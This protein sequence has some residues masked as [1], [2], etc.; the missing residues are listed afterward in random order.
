MT[1]DPKSVVVGAVLALAASALFHAGYGLF[2]IAADYVSARTVRA[3]I[4]ALIVFVIAVL[5]F[6]AFRLTL[7]I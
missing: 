5:A 2:S 6:L 3:G 7:F 4:A 1:L